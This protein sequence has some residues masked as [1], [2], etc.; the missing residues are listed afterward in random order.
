MNDCVR[1][2]EIRMVELLHD[3]QELKSFMRSVQGAAKNFMTR[4]FVIKSTCIHFFIRMVGK[5][6]VSESLFFLQHTLKK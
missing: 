3:V 6:K 2:H 5:F 4:V 1:K